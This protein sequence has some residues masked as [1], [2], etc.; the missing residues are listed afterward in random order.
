MAETK[1]VNLTNFD[2]SKMGVQGTHNTVRRLF[3]DTVEAPVM[4]QNDTLRVLRLPVDAQLPSLRFACDDL[5]TTG[6]F[7]IGIAY[8]TYFTPAGGTAGAVIAAGAFATAL[9]VK[10]AAVAFTDYRFSVKNID[11][12]QKKLWELAGLS[13]RP[14]CP[15]L[16]ILITATTAVDVGG[17]VSMIADAAVMG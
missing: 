1:S 7:S 14:I 15:E 5:G 10:T 12:V 8:P 4:A 6:A 13:A 11:T 16:D 2:S 9:D 3:A 17:T